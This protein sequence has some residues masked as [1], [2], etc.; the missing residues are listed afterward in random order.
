VSQL[1]QWAKGGVKVGSAEPLL[2]AAGSGKLDAG[3][4]L[5][6]E[7]GANVSQLHNGYTALCVAAQEGHEHVVRALVQEFVANVNQARHDGFT[8]LN[9]AAEKGQEHV[10]LCLLGEGGADVNR[11]NHLG[12]TPVL[13]AV[14]CG[15]VQVLRPLKEVGA[16]I[17]IASKSGFTPLIIAASSQNVGNTLDVLRCLLGE[18]GADVNQVPENG[19]TALFIAAQEGHEH[20]LR[21]LV[22]EFGADVNQA[23]GH[24]YSPLYAAAKEGNEHIVRYLLGECGAMSTNQMTVAPRLCTSLRSWGMGMWCGA[25][26]R[27]LVPTST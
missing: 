17:N 5:L 9:I 19:C 2:K 7:L 18:F 24:G 12:E 27:N 23:A 8:P 14:A 22:Q 11:P 25:S 15:H 26:S 4:I 1:V 16:D 3:R 10:A 13:T 20:V 6:K 21:C